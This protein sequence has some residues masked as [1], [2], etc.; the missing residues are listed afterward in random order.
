MAAW[1]RLLQG[2]S[3][4]QEVKRQ[5]CLLVLI[6]CGSLPGPGQLQGGGNR[7]RVSPWRE[8]HVHEWLA[9]ILEDLPIACVF[10]DK[11]PAAGR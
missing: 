1:P 4:T 6:W 3:M 2:G 8:Q 7:Y 10:K 9:T 11:L 5:L